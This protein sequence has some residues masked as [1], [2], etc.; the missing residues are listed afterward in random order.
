MARCRPLAT[1]RAHRCASAAAPSGHGSTASSGTQGSRQRGGS[2]GV[3]LAGR[4]H[5]GDSDGD[6]VREYRIGADFGPFSFDV[7]SERLGHAA[8][9]TSSAWDRTTSW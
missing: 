6:G 1:T 3:G 2:A 7:K 8:D 5:Y 4:V 9:G